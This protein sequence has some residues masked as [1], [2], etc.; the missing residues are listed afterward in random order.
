MIPCT[1][2]FSTDKEYVRRKIRHSGYCQYMN[3]LDMGQAIVTI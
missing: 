1:K 3:V 2:D